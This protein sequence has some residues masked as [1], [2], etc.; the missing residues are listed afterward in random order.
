ML[1]REVKSWF[2]TCGLWS[3]AVCQHLAGGCREMNCVPTAISFLWG[4]LGEGSV[5]TFSGGCNIYLTWAEAILMKI[6]NN[7]HTH[8]PVSS[9]SGHILPS[10]FILNTLQTHVYI[11]HGPMQLYN[12][13]QPCVCLTAPVGK[14]D[15]LQ[16]GTSSLWG[17][18]W[19]ISRKSLR[20]L[21]FVL[22]WVNGMNGSGGRH[23]SKDLIG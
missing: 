18:L 21:V 17:G 22:I 15:H 7:T 8:I 5:H 10:V 2:T 4:S 11:L 23:N 9:S 13:Y 3:G 6:W 19:L 14:P 20:T 12:L 1:P 16:V